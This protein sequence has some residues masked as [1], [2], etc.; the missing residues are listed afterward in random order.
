[1]G[2][3]RLMALL[4]LA[5]LLVSATASTYHPES[6]PVN[7]VKWGTRGHEGGPLSPQDLEEGRLRY[8][9]IATGGRKLLA[10]GTVKWFNKAVGDTSNNQKSGGTGRNLLGHDDHLAVALH[11][12]G[13]RKLTSRHDERN[14]ALDGC[15]REY[16]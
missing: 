5:C 8:N 2:N 7:G 15:G 10:T 1:M 16:V 4:L 6:A 14:K 12:N 11:N 9:S 3:L 13:D